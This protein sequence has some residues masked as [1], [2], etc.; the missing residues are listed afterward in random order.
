MIRD[1]S[2]N[3]YMQKPGSGER[4]HIT[5]A[6]DRE[7]IGYMH[8]RQGWLQVPLWC[9][10][11]ATGHTCLDFFQMYARHNYDP[12]FVAQTFET[13]PRS[14]AEDQRDTLRD[15]LVVGGSIGYFH[16]LMDFLPRLYFLLED[17]T[18]RGLSLVVPRDFRDDH[19]T[20]LLGL[21]ARLGWDPPRLV[22]VDDGFHPI[23]NAV[24]PG[25]IGR[26][27]A[28]A[29][30]SKHLYPPPADPPAQR[31]RLFVRR[32][33]TTRRRL[34]NDE[35]IA[36]SLR[37]RGFVCIDPG[38]L[39]FDEQVALFRDAGVVVGVHG[40]GLTNLLFAPEDG[41][42]IELFYGVQQPF[43]R[44]LALVRRIRHVPVCGTCVGD[45]SNADQDFSIPTEALLKIVDRL[46]AG[47]SPSTID[48]PR[49]DYKQIWTADDLKNIVPAGHGHDP[50]GW[51]PAAHLK[52]TIKPERYERVLDFGCGWGRLC[53]TFSCDQYLGVDLNPNAIEQARTLHPGYRFAEVD[54]DSTFDTADLIVAYT[55]FLH[56][57]DRTLSDLLARLR[58]ACRDCLVIAEILGREWRRPG[59]PPVFNRDLSDYANLLS[60]HNFSYRDEVRRPYKR[61]AEDPRF[62]G[63]NTD[64]S[65]LVFGVE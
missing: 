18:L 61:Y 36:S 14:A 25:F 10:V 15:V 29:I 45:G 59:H 48:R 58:P 27:S 63:R 12:L 47:D 53:S 31:N 56:L 51:N 24:V 50:E 23:R 17:P 32:T 49:P 39:T 55:V 11:T 44:D 38:T 21:Y 3:T 35:Q 54:L 19:R 4:L 64:L 6:S 41:V 52:K 42:L 8:L 5:R 22:E 26:H 16:C 34:I 62:Q 46:I 20:I 37:Q 9:P 28:S 1:V 13:L 30:W 2:I 57:D 43:F 40:A 7:Q 65:V 33:Q 60:Q